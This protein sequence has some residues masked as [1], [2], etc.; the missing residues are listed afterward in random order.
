MAKK[1]ETTPA[2]PGGRSHRATFARD[3]RKGGYLI[4]VQG[5]HSESFAGRE[6]PVT[7]KDGSENTEKLD[8]LVWSGKD[9]E[10]GE[11]VTLYTFVPKPKEQ[12]DEI[13]F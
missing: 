3:K 4:R 10:T 9:Q 8:R 13:E 11:P 1:P 7:L 12:Q 6:V 5:P 2:R